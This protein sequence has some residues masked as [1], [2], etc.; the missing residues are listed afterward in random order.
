MSKSVEQLLLVLSKEEEI[1]NNVIAMS[2]DKQN[3]IIKKNM[4]V[5]DEIV[6]KEKAYS[7]SL[8][9]LEEIRTRLLDQLV[10]EYGLVE[11]NNISDLYP[12]MS[13]GDTIKI[14]TI[15]NRLLSTVQILSGRNET[16]K[17][18]IE[19]SLD[20]IAFD[21]DLYTM[22]GDGSVNYKEDADDKDVERKSIFDRK[23]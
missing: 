2:A 21:M 19:Q 10:M 13:R 4:D 6:K 3:A 16:N 23:I 20:Q 7:I 8:A 22:V 11:I 14:D 17:R 1:Y 15:K 18:L 5:L 12:Y 9:K